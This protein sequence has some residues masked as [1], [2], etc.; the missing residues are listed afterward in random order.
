MNPTPDLARL[1][2]V[3]AAAPFGFEELER[4][5]AMRARRQR[6]AAWGAAASVAFLG[7]VSLAAVL[8][9]PPA[10]QTG[11]QLAQA[12]PVAQVPGRAAPA[13]RT[14]PP[15]ALVDLWQFD[16]TSELEDHIAVLDAELSAAR[17][18]AASGERVRQMERTREQLHDSLQRVAYAHDLLDL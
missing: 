13:E 9:Q 14:A 18:G 15:P 17:T 7:L 6:R 2:T 10:P 5:C 4:R 11:L 16:L 12:V 8:T 3:A 1:A